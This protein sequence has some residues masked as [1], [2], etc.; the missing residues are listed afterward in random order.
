MTTAKRNTYADCEFIRQDPTES[1]L[2]SVGITDTAGTEFYAVNAHV[3]QEVLRTDP[4]LRE[5]VL[6][7][8]PLTAAG[9]LD[10][11]HPHV[12]TPDQIRVGLAAYYAAGPPA[13]FHAY[14][15]AGDLMRLH[16]LWEHRWDVMPQQIPRR[17][18]ELADLLEDHGVPEPV[19]ASPEHHALNDARHNR[20]IHQAVLTALGHGRPA[21]EP[22]ITLPR[23]HDLLRAGLRYSLRPG[24]GRTPAE[25]AAVLSP[26][27]AAAVRAHTPD[28]AA[29]HQTAQAAHHRYITALENWISAIPTDPRSPTKQR[30]GPEQPDSGRLQPPV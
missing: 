4:F 27:T 22:A 3:D 9:D 20:D 2:I 18:R 11:D 7:K 19:Q 5:Q 28:L 16:A 23:L 6:P 14:F 13:L 8:L 26:D 25:L 15:G 21:P 17:P 12:R 1:G 30:P 10:L 29:L 24:C